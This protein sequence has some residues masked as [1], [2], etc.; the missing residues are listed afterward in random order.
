MSSPVDRQPDTEAGYQQNVLLPYGEDIAVADIHDALVIKEGNLFLMSDA[1]GNLPS[2][3]DQGYG[4]YKGDTRYL[5]V[6]DLSLGDVRPVVLLSTAENGY[7][8]EHH[9]TNPPMRTAAGRAVPTRS[10]EIRRQ[11]VISG[12]L[13]ET[14]QVTNFDILPVTL[15]LRFRFAADFQDI[16]E[17]RGEKRDRRG[18][19]L[20]P[21]I[22][23]DRVVFAYLGLDHVRRSTELRFSVPPDELTED[24]AVFHRQLAHMESFDLTISIIPDGAHAEA[25]L[26]ATSERLSASYRDWID[27]C[28]QVVTDNEFFN[29]MWERSLRDLRMLSI[30]QEQG[31][32][33]AAGTPWFSAL[34]GRDSIITAL[35]TLAFKPQLA[36]DTLRLLAARQGRRVDEW[37][38]EE[39][40]KIL[41]EVREGE[42]A[43]MHEIPMTPYYGSV[44]STPLFLVLAAEYVAW[45]GDLDLVRELEPQLLAALDWVDR[46]TSAN[47]SG[48]LDYAS[49]S[50]KGLLNQGWK[51]SHDG[52]VNGDGTL[53]RPPIALVE[54]QGYVY[55]A[56]RG[57]AQLFDL[58]G[59]PELA[60]ARRQQAAA[61]KRRFND[62]FWVEE[63]R[64]FALALGAEHRPA[65]AVTSNP[66]HCL[67]AGIVERDKAAAVAE[68]LFENDM[69]SGWG[70][71]TLSSRTPRYNPLGYHLGSV[72]PH[73][74]SIIGMGLKRYGFEEEL[75]DLA[76]ATY[77]CCRSFD[78]YRLPEPFCGTPRTPHSAPVR[79]PVAARPQAWAA[80]T[81]PLILQ[82]ILGLAPNASRNELRLVS[83]RLPHWLNE[84]ELHGLRIGARAVDLRF[85][86]QDGPAKVSVL[87]NDGVDVVLADRWPDL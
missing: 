52:I 55:A 50:S 76:T 21:E 61:F 60:E 34:F 81:V 58:L 78:Y 51:D 74:N 44:D 29:A 11:R 49:R 56:Q 86:R 67:W 66:G 19:L 38:D 26:P 4:L 85:E 5:S 24:G 39:P 71:R 73:D 1:D 14:I 23:Q 75:D 45:T 2:G 30:E 77:D 10:I 59:K 82:A 3:V 20:E 8:S 28:T 36:R 6:Y 69:F 53:V 79:Y 57:M 72:W 7:S 64:F 25:S 43:S 42:M 22:E 31:T 84:V 9:L 17:F 18:E 27:S 40:G 68:R 37:R 32:F 62:D 54:V 48:Y 41:H 13:T 15:T 70:I 35:Q 16:F 63:D 12:S 65:T 87:A 46:R 83:P 47:G 33:V 80:G